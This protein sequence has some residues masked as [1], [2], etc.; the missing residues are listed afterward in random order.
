MPKFNTGTEY[1]QKFHQI[2]KLGKKK[3]VIL[4]YINGVTQE[5][6]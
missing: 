4:Y 6:Y 2:V 3:H 1:G 5:K